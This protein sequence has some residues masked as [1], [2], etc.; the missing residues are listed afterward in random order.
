MLRIVPVV[1]GDG[2]VTAVPAL[3]SRVL[4][5][6]SCYTH[7]VGSPKNAH[8]RGN[9][10]VAG[11]LEKFV[12]YAAR[13]RDCGAVLVL[14]DSE[15]DCPVTLACDL[16]AR[17]SAL[18][19]EQPV[20]IVVAHCCYENWLLAG[21]QTIRGQELDGRPGVAVD[22]PDLP[23]PEGV[24]SPKNW[25]TERMGR[26]RAYKETEDQVAMTRLLDVSD[27]YTKARSFKRLVDA[28]SEALNY[29]I[30]APRGTV[31]PLC[32]LPN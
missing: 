30:P 11:G 8:G 24:A 22:A 27:V 19:L 1:E 7:I 25:L 17:A 4:S 29:E 26:G 18:Q 3:I 23:D 28:V 15:G 6:H 32:L 21:I 2:E 12:R 10:T 13:E 16:A 20:V 9:L 5:H 31:T 14:L